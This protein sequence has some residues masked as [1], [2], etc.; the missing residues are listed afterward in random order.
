LLVRADEGK[1]PIDGLAG[2][3]GVLGVEWRHQPTSFATIAR[4]PAWLIGAVWT[5]MLGAIIL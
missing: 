3:E 2:R 5:F 1:A 4:K